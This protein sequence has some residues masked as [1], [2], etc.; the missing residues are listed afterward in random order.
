MLKLNLGTEILRST[1][2]EA[3]EY[4]LAT[5]QTCDNRKLGGSGEL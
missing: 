3:N 5:K 1:F 2:V 4:L